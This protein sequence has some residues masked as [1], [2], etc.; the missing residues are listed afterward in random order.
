MHA[1]Y[2]DLETVRYVGDAELLSK[3]SCLEWVEITDRNFERR[4]YGMVAFVDRASG[5]I[6]GCGGIVHP[7]QQE[8]P[9]V[10]YAFRRDQWGKGYAS[11]AV[12]A[13][14]GY[15]RGHWGVS[16][17]IA[18]AHPENSPSHRVLAKGGFTHAQDRVNEDGSITQVWESLG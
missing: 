9:E 6:V 7:G 3:E 18:T 11:E 15:A 5:E 13:L 8:E 14:V 10:K 16:R 1:I 2:G 17:I 4:G 12:I